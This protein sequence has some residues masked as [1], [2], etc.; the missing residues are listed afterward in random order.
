MVSRLLPNVFLMPL[1][2]N[3]NQQSKIHRTR[4]DFGVTLSVQLKVVLVLNAHKLIVYLVC[5]NNCV[6]NLVMVFGAC[7]TSKAISN[8]S[9]LYCFQ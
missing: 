3:I 5:T 6:L 7:S 8:V 1:Q 2:L 4:Y 9:N